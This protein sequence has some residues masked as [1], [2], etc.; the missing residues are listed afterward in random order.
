MAGHLTI[1]TIGHSNHPLERFER[2]L[3][4]AGI[5]AVADVRS[6]PYSRHTPHFSKDELKHSLREIGVAYSYLGHELGGRPRDK[7]FYSA[8]T[9]DYEKMA[10]A[11]S[12]KEGVSR[13]MSGATKYRIALLCSEHDPLDCHR[14]LLVGRE[15][16]RQ[17]VCVEHILSDGSIQTHSDVEEKLLK[18]AGNR[19]EDFFMPRQERIDSAYRER[20]RRVAYSD[21]EQP[22]RVVQNSNGSSR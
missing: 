7:S 9:A 21:Q 14:C 19:D 8:G 3:K 20:S 22:D 4:S 13:V 1:F 17:G 18:T 5:T 15:L 2:L 10:Q 16:S 6:A 12:F 11:P